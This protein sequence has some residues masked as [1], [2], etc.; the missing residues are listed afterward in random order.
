M[1]LP[2]WATE[3]SKVRALE[4]R[5]DRILKKRRA[6]TKERELQD[7]TDVAMNG[8]SVSHFDDDM[9]KAVEYQYEGS[10]L[11]YHGYTFI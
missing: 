11:N 1:P 7:N 6:I 9:N 2:I 4:T 8:Y 5:E 10:N 3:K